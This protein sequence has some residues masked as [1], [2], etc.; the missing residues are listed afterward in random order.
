MG[1]NPIAGHESGRVA[2]DILR[3]HAR[4]LNSVSEDQ[5]SHGDRLA[6]IEKAFRSAC[7]VADR[8]GRLPT[9]MSDA[10]ERVMPTQTLTQIRVM[11]GD[12]RRSEPF[13]RRVEYFQHAGRNA[14]ATSYA[15]I[16]SKTSVSSSTTNTNTNTNTT[17]QGQGQG[18]GQTG[19]GSGVGVPGS[20]Y[21]KKEYLPPPDVTKS[22]WLGTESFSFYE[23][24]DKPLA[25]AVL[26]VIRDRV[27]VR[28]QGHKGHI[29]ETRVRREFTN[30]SGHPHTYPGFIG[31]SS[32]DFLDNMPGEPTEEQKKHILGFQGDQG[33]LHF[34]DRDSLIARKMGDIRAESARL[35]N[36]LPR[37][38]SITLQDGKT[39][40]HVNNSVFSRSYPVD[41]WWAGKN[42][43][44]FFKNSG[45]ISMWNSSDQGSQMMMTGNPREQF[46]RFLDSIK[47]AM[48]KE[49]TTSNKKKSE[50]CGGWEVPWIDLFDSTT[51]NNNKNNNN[52]FPSETG[53]GGG[54]S[55]YTFEEMIQAIQNL[56]S[57]DPQERNK[58]IAQVRK[59]Q[60]EKEELE[61]EE[62]QLEKGEKGEKGDL[63]KRK[64]TTESNN[65]NAVVSAENNKESNNA[66]AVS[67]EINK[68]SKDS[69]LTAASNTN[70][71]STKES[72]VAW[73][74]ERSRRL[75]AKN[76][77]EL[78]ETLVKRDAVYRL[79]RSIRFA[80][81]DSS[82]NNLPKWADI[83]CLRDVEDLVREYE[84][85]QR[86][87]LKEP[88]ENGKKKGLPDIKSVIAREAQIVLF[89]FMDLHRGLQCGIPHRLDKCTS[90]AMVGCWTESGFGSLK[91]LWQAKRVMKT[92]VTVVCGWLELPQL[93]KV[94]LGKSNGPGATKSRV[95]ED[96]TG[97][98]TLSHAFP[99]FK[100][101][102]SNGDKYTLVGVEIMTGFTHQIR[103]IM[104]KLGYPIVND[105]KYGGSTNHGG[106]NEDFLLHALGICFPL[107]T[108][109]E[110]PTPTSVLSGFGGPPPPK[111]NIIRH[112]AYLVP[113]PQEF[114]DTWVRILSPDV[115]LQPAYYSM[116]HG[117]I[118]GFLGQSR[119]AAFEIDVPELVV[120]GGKKIAI[121]HGLDCE[122]SLERLRQMDTY[123]EKGIPGA[124]TQGKS[125]NSIQ[126]A[127][128]VKKLN[129][130][131]ALPL[132]FLTLDE[133]N[134]I[135]GEGN[136]G[137]NDNYGFNGLG[138]KSLSN[139]DCVLDLIFPVQVLM[140]RSGLTAIWEFEER[141]HHFL[142]T[143]ADKDFAFP[144]SPR[145]GGGRRR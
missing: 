98:L 45:L 3:E 16:P 32:D 27:K 50:V 35:E 6:L 131:P 44:L 93:I 133:G 119:A 102:A 1:V 79:L 37:T 2:V 51:D 22:R 21:V 59:Q 78:T 61:K 17:A 91:N 107:E 115:K 9:M 122:V 55:S 14:V 10:D 47:R 125:S 26:R 39:K 60:K 53:G 80:F 23:H 28:K 132:T 110:D 65:G 121:R 82:K 135:Y 138:S 64:I 124:G 58:M 83:R 56:K 18:Q 109:K 105:R 11:G 137:Q 86:I 31:Y 5:K 120:H 13:P 70:T 54:E 43:T 57:V 106:P 62:Q 85:E 142:V 100:T 48:D 134:G 139:P 144:R 87:L 73:E 49:A 36:P 72:S 114:W 76:G 90:G 8:S 123:N 117:S 126:R 116:L 103:V 74:A 19:G 24:Q 12:D 67:A 92:Y 88:L 38:D 129:V 96:G 77:F 63:K 89:R 101:K 71:K 143:G 52:N 15:L 7:E 118:A 30:K 81:G 29:L 111:R 20:S 4:S 69:N 108:S 130:N 25:L 66:N 112:R 136:I 68:E 127:Q 104:Q 95:S 75:R 40:L 141:R 97:S 34:S 99:L 84:R 46:Q 113:P 41:N 42:S 128:L 145:R 94:A 140:R 33:W